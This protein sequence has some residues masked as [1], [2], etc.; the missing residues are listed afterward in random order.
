MDTDVSE[1]VEM[2]V[3]GVPPVAF[4]YQVL[5]VWRKPTRIM[6]MLHWKFCIHAA[7]IG[8]KRTDVIPYIAWAWK[9]PNMDK[10]FAAT[11]AAVL[12]NPKPAATADAIRARPEI[13]AR[14]HPTA[15]W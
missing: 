10:V 14:V 1:S 12:E 13:T 11:W 6:P 15:F 7:T 3:D 8:G 9:N 4:W 2:I 5:I